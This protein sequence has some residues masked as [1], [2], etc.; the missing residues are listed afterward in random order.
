MI[1]R[2]ILII[3]LA[4]TLGASPGFAQQK[5]SRKERKALRAE[6]QGSR[7][8]I[9]G[10][11]QLVLDSM[12]KAYFYF[13]KA[14][15]FI[16]E[17]PAIHYKL[18]EVL[19]KANQAEKALPYANK[20]ADL[21]DQNKYYSLMLAEIYT[22]LNQPLK[23]A[24]ILDQLTA[25]G[26]SNQQYNLDLASIYLN[27]K[28]YKK[29]LVVLDRAEEYYGVMEPIT[30]Q[31]Q[32]IYLNA[33][34]LEKAIEEGKNLIEARPGNPDYVMNLVEILFNNN[35][36]EEAM[37]VVQNEMSKYPNQPELQMAAYTLLKE[38]GEIEESNRYL[39]QAFASPDLDPDV[40]SKAY[41]G[42]LNEIKTQERDLVL[43]SLE[44]LM[45]NTSP[46]NAQIFTAI[47]QRKMLENKQPEAIEFYKKA[48][49]LAPKN[50]KMLEQ[51][52]LG[53]FGENANLE[54]LEKFT[55]LGV[56]EFPQRPEFWFYDG[57]VK[58]ALKKDQDAVNSL[59]KALELNSA[60]NSQL[61]QV[62]Y[63]SLG[64][65]YYNLGEK[66]KAF[67]YFDK[68]L[69]LNPNDEQ[70][71]NNYSYFLSLEKQDLEK[72]K[73][74]SDKVVRRFPDNGTF[75]DTHA[76]VLFQLKDY[77]GAKKYMDLALEHEAEPSAVMMEHYGDI[78]YHLGKKSEAITYWKK[79]EGSPE[80]SEYLEQKIKEGKYHE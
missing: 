18:A 56:D 21:D 29:A 73:S 38:K 61:E 9:E 17:E 45:L 23:A 71:L 79:A 19:V 75:L 22:N 50:D 80:A 74:M 77:Q 58:S 31:K 1:F 44:T 12:E 32:R 70:V 34:N 24:E 16:P 78:L 53:S 64:N 63:S 20:A 27:A 54:E 40:K 48:L 67:E 35:R 39:F 68:A 66:E 51:V 33:N 55:V 41:I 36:L 4:L 42:T 3:F 69:K 49:L 76:W 2:K 57:V 25:D 8:F 62:A 30:V 59:N 13:Q 37:E 10:E 11:K 15:E 47:G 43:D 14:L 52:I 60:N 28:A 6:S 72:A 26:E 7:Y 46:E 5:L 65:S